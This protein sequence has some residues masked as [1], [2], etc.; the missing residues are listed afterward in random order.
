ML[1]GQGGILSEFHRNRMSAGKIQSDAAFLRNR[2]FTVGP[3]TFHRNGPLKTPDGSHRNSSVVTGEAEFGGT[4]G[5]LWLTG[6][7]RA[8]IGLELARRRGN[9]I[10][11]RSFSR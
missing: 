8:I 3:D 6:H 9:V 1:L 4:I 5:L 10:P 7:R 11:Q 2:N